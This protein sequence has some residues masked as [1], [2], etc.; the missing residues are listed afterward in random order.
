M[1]AYI[2]DLE[3]AFGKAFPQGVLHV[4]G[5]LC[6][7]NLHLFLTPRSPSENPHE[8]RRLADESVYQTLARHHG[9]VSAEHGIGRE[10]KDWLHISR[11]SEEI[12]LMRKLKRTLDPTNILNRGLVFDVRSEEHTSELQSLM[13]ISYAVFCL[14]KKKMK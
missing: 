12:A 9:A 8:I 1:D 3:D 5:H 2:S 11:S 14:K 10:K 13:R 4:F 7:G 6:D